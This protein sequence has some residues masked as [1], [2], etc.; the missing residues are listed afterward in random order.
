[1]KIFDEVAT[2]TMAFVTSVPVAIAM[3]PAEFTMNFVE[4]LFSKFRNWP[5]YVPEVLMPINVPDA[6]PPKIF[7]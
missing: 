7:P 1:V 4:E 3:E 6:E 2:V 5:L